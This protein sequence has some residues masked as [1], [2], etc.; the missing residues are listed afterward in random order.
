MR[1]LEAAVID[2]NKQIGI[3]SAKS[4]IYLA[5]NN[6]IASNTAD[7]AALLYAALV[8]AMNNVIGDVFESKYHR[9]RLD[10]LYAKSNVQS[11]ES[12]DALVAAVGFIPQ[13]RADEQMNGE[14]NTARYAALTA[15]VNGELLRLRLLELSRRWRDHIRPS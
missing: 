5:L 3:F 15:P 7:S 12:A 1:L 9:I 10:K 11:V 4:P 13:P 2:I 14:S 6:M 8:S